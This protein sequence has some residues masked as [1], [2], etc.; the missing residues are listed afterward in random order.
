VEKVVHAQFTEKIGV[1]V[2][3]YKALP[4]TTPDGERLLATCE[5]LKLFEIWGERGKADAVKL[6]KTMSRC[7]R[8]QCVQVLTENLADNV[9]WYGPH[10]YYVL[11]LECALASAAFQDWLYDGATT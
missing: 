5:R 11:L 8:S 9:E 1:A 6:K 10:H 4:T 3:A 2:I 7:P